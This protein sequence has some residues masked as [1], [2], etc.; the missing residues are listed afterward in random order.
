MD[1]PLATPVPWDLVADGYVSDVVPQFT[2]YAEAAL[3]LA[4]VPPGG[5]VVDV[6]CG[7]GTLTVL[8][9]RSA[10]R[11][12]AIDF[13]PEMIAQ[14]ARVA[15]ANVVPRVGDGQALPYDDAS[16]DAGFSMFGLIFFPDRGRGLAELARVLR[17][18]GR[19]AISSW[20][21]AE[22]VPMMEA[23]FRALKANGV[24]LPDTRPPLSEPA[25]FEAELGGAGF[26][27]V[28]VEE[29]GNVVTAPS[30]DELWAG[31]NRSMAPLV[32]MRKRM[33]EATWAGFGAAIRQ[34]LLDRFGAGPQRF[35]QPA[36]IGVGTR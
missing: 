6:A 15:P 29:V 28:R 30:L 19:V 20:P 4:A 5:R 12:D 18:G 3:R 25:D 33:G 17:P 13:A 16:F 35:E 10:E 21:R 22:R 1:N 31:F 34:A 32:L 14:L 24:P 26:R 8:A 36:W 9:A 2:P 11:V 7:P 23:L 27:D